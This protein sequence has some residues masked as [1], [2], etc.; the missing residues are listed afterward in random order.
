MCVCE[1]NFVNTWKIECSLR[2]CHIQC[3]VMYY[4]NNQDDKL[5]YKWWIEMVVV[6]GRSVYACMRVYMRD[7]IQLFGVINLHH[8]VGSVCMCTWF[9]TGIWGQCVWVYV[10]LVYHGHYRGHYQ[11]VISFSSKWGRCV[12]VSMWIW[13]RSGTNLYIITDPCSYK[14]PPKL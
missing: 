2:I 14:R 8:K 3:K 12:S 7:L 6:W 11:A 10:Y 13:F 1:Y 5:K 9:V 4:A